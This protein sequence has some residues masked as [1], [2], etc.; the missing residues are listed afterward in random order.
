MQ[1]FTFSGSPPNLMAERA[2][3]IDS[4]SYYRYQRQID[5]IFTV[6]LHLWVVCL[7]FIG[8]SGNFIIFV[9]EYI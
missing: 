1:M 2:Y 5:I 6:L 7:L 9:A 4:N 8:S 3:F